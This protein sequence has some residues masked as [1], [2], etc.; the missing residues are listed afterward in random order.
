LIHADKGW[1][2]ASPDVVIVEANGLKGR[3]EIKT[4]VACWDKPIE[5]A[6]E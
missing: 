1:L 2:G 3:V 6:I 5:E 4:V